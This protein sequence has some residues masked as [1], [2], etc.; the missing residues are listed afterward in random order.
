[1]R[2]HIHSATLH[3]SATEQANRVKLRKL[4]KN[5][6][7]NKSEKIAG[8][9]FT[10]FWDIAI[11]VFGGVFPNHPI[12][13]EEYRLGFSVSHCNM[14]FWTWVLTEE[15]RLHWSAKKQGYFQSTEDHPR[16]LCCHNLQCYSMT[17]NVDNL[18]R[19]LQCILK[20]KVSTFK[21]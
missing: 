17:L 7:L 11:F 19:C 18:K 6:P 3:H 16:A 2:G 5:F 10:C 15:C 1:M 9:I 14:S 20:M 8:K 13:Q 4:L 21:N 12:S